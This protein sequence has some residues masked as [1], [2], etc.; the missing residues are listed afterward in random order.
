MAFIKYA[1]VDADRHAE[2]ELP[3]GTLAASLRLEPLRQELLRIGVPIK[4]Q[5]SKDEMLDAYAA[6]LERGVSA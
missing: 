1:R 2:L 6:E 4:P 3:D 5:M